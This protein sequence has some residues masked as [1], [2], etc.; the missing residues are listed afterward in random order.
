MMNLLNFSSR[1]VSGSPVAANSSSVGLMM[2]CSII[3]PSSG[4]I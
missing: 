3:T 4:N 2:V 1:I